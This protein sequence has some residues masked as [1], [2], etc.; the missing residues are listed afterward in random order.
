LSNKEFRRIVQV[1]I[2][3]RDIEEARFAWAQLLGVEQPPIVETEGWESTH[4]TF[5]DTPSNG[6][7]KLAFFKLENIIIELIQPIGG[8]S[9][10][11]GFLA[12]HGDGIHHIAFNIQDLEATLE[13]LEEM[14]IGVEQRGD[15]KGGCYVYADSKGKLGATIELL[16]SHREKAV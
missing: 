16:H 8:P 2:M 12:E 14:G 6:R 9:T 4:M 13:R 1:G 3:V 5:K 7:A 10:W 11:Q 15:Y